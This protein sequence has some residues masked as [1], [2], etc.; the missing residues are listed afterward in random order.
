MILEVFSIC[1]DSMIFTGEK[2]LR[3]EKEILYSQELSRDSVGRDV[4][5]SIRRQREAE[6]TLGRAVSPN[7]GARSA[8]GLNVAFC[9][10]LAENFDC[11]VRMFLQGN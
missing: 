8:C 9:Q 11:T 6:G 7:S 10:G 4:P 2:K 1:N 3:M 5:F